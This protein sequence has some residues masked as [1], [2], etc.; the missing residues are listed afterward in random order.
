VFSV[1]SNSILPFAH[2]K[3]DFKKEGDANTNTNTA[4]SDSDSTAMAQARD[5]II[6]IIIGSSSQ[7]VK[8]ITI[9]YFTN[10]FN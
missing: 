1:L 9:I 6:I 2:K 10:L 3:S 5:L 4:T 7:L 8:P